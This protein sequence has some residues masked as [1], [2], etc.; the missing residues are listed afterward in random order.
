EK[1]LIFEP[2]LAGDWIKENENAQAEVWK[3]EKKGDL[4]YRL[5]VIEEQKAT[6]LEVHAFKLEGE[7]FLDVFSLDQDIH[8]IPPHY[9]LRVTQLK[10][11]LRMSEL[12]KDWLKALLV[13]NPDAIPHCL[14]RDG[15]KPEDVRVVL[16]APTCELQSFI[17]KHLN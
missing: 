7:L 5:T 6:V 13:Q 15:D 1:D 11:T 16:T 9:L 8:V 3:F 2:A 12:D 14:V 17:L 4:A 10:P